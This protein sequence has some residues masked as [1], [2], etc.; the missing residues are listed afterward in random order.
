M[1]IKDKFYDGDFYLQN[2]C[3]YNNYYYKDEVKEIE[4]N[5]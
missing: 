3:V 2:N 5:L 1:T 4:S